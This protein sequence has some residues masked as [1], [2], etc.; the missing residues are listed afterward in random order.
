MTELEFSDP[1]WAEAFAA[2]GWR[3]FEDLWHLEASEVEPGNV[4][5]G[6]WSSVVR[7]TD[8]AGEAYYLKRQE[9][10]D[11]RAWDGGIARRPTVVREWRTGIAFRGFGIETA[12]PVC[13]GVNRKESSRGLLV[14]RAL[15]A[16]ESLEDVL[17]R[18][19]GG[20]DIRQRLWY[21]IADDVLRIHL[22][23]YRHNCLYGQHILVH[24]QD[25]DWTCAFIDLEKATRTRRPE[26]AA[27]ADLSALDRHTNDMSLRDREWL[28]DR[29]F[30]S[31]ALPRREKI[32]K[33]LA[34]RTALRGVSR[35]IRDCESGR[36]GEMARGPAA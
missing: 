6:G 28:W 18:L 35:Y 12:E 1:R 9:N 32:L 13:L 2:S 4:R 21:R 17:R 29:Y 11:Y 26:R 20:S 19:P 14:T 30:R 33:E 25:G 24:E 34:R 31:V 36:R 27:I 5:R 3:T 16:H 10:H 22:H 15:D 7:F 23:G 8:S